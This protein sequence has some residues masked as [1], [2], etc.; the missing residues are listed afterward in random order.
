MP[1]AQW[2]QAYRRFEDEGYFFIMS[3]SHA[4]KGCE[5]LER[6]GSPMPKF[7]QR[8]ALRDWR[9]V[10][11]HWDDPGNGRPIQSLADWRV[12]SNERAPGLS[13]SGADKVTRLSG[14]R[15]RWLRQDLRGLRQAAGSVSEREWKRCYIAPIEAASIL[16]I[17]VSE[18]EGMP[19][20]PLSHDFGA[21]LGRRYWREWVDARANGE[22]R[23]PDW[24]D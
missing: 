13:F 21:G 10:E 8:V 14:I 11:E 6:R 2:V 1:S 5:L 15:V 23:P 9:N 3:V 4:I 17:T 18:L 19:H 24:D 12:V 16:G 20:P 22:L 7:R